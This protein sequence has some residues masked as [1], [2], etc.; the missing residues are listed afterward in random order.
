MKRFLYFLVALLLLTSCDSFREYRC[1]STNQ[2]NV[3]HLWSTK[4][5]SIIVKWMPNVKNLTPYYDELVDC[6]RFRNGYVPQ[7]ELL[8][9]CEND[10]VLEKFD[11]YLP[12]NFVSF[13]KDSGV[14]QL[15]VGLYA[16]SGA[17][18][19]RYFYENIENVFFDIYSCSPNSCVNATKIHVHDDSSMFNQWL[20]PE[21]FKIEQ[22]DSKSSDL[23]YYR[24]YHFRLNIDAPTMKAVIKVECD[25]VC[26]DHWNSFRLPLGG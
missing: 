19:K 14:V 9:V 18:A 17:N 6:E 11:L 24:F 16:S 23:Y 4:L 22:T 10:A 20:S 8:R 7:H 1:R 12:S 5:D 21:N 15:Q 26:Y 3:E 2:V 13:E 25:S